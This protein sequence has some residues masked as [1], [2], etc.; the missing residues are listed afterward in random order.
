MKTNWVPAVIMLMAGLIDCIISI[1]Y[2]LSLWQFTKQLLLVLII[3][4][5][6]GCVVKIVL[7]CNFKEMKEEIPEDNAE[8]ELHEEE[9]GEAEDAEDTNDGEEHLDKEDSE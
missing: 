4:Y 5:V 1:Y 8:A 9:A 2:H 3:F 7:D 6:I